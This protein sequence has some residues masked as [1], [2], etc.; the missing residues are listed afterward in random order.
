MQFPTPV[1]FFQRPS[2]NKADSFPL[3]SVESSSQ[4]IL[5]PFFM[6]AP[7]DVDRWR[8]FGAHEFACPCCGEFFLDEYSFDCLQ[9]ARSIVGSPFKINSAHRCPIHNARVG[10]KPLS[11]HKKIAFDISIRNH[12]FPV[13]VFHACR[14]AGFT[15]FGFYQTFIHVDM[16][17][18]RRWFSGPYGRKKWNSL[19]IY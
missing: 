3:G 4:P 10:G 1:T 2:L 6:D 18:P 9:V 7:W 12:P 19:G 16:G 11:Q 14:D 8:N 5:F 17:R 15:G 13:K